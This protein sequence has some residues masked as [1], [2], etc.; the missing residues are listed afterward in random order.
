[1]AFKIGLCSQKGGPG[2]STIARGTAVGF[3]QLG[4]NAKI[5]DFD[6]GQ[7]TATEWLRIR[8]AN[9][10][11]PDV[12]AE[13]F[14]SVAQALRNAANYDVMIFDPKG[15]TSTI[16]V[17]IA[18]ASD[19]VIIPTALALDD[20]RP[21]V[22]LA[23]QIHTKHGTPIERIVFALNHVGDSDAE[24]ADAQAYLS[25]KPYQVL[26]GH[27]SEKVAYRRAMDLGL[28]ILET[29]YKGPREQAERLIQAIMNKV[30]EL[31]V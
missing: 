30:E 13:P 3:A 28:S 20:L 1:M 2:K 10:H 16:T 12:Y 18:K 26:D 7:L 6:L 14:G 23:D 25:Q 21:A 17:E 15:E 24:L 11:K 19:L 9:G 5:A 31:T 4:W 29:P 22:V 8:L 27:L